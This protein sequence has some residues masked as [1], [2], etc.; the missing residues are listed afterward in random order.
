MK[1]V[2]DHSIVQRI[3]TAAAASDD[4]INREFHSQICTLH[5]VSTR[6]T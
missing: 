3:L 5:T 6:G 4:G 1:M 2:I